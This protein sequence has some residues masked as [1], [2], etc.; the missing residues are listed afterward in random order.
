MCCIMEVE[1]LEKVDRRA[2]TN[3]Q[4]EKLFCSKHIFVTDGI[5]R[6]CNRI[7]DLVVL[8]KSL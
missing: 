8:L 3:P 1:K 4:R 5:R 2:T 7:E 6:C